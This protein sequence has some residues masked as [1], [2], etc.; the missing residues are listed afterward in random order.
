MALVD[1]FE[2]QPAA[3]LHQVD[4][5]EVAGAE[6]DDVAIGDVVLGLLLLSLPVASLM[7]WPTIELCS[8][9]PA[10]PWTSPRASER[11]TSSSSP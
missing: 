3:L 7:A 9:P 10:I 4:E 6:H 1:L 5:A 8:S 11:S 2:R